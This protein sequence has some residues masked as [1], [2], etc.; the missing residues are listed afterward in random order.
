MNRH[1][2]KD[3]PTGLT[4]DKSSPSRAIK[5]GQVWPLTLAKVRLFG[6]TGRGRHWGASCPTHLESSL[7]ICPP[8]ALNVFAPRASSRGNGSSPP[9]RHSS[10]PVEFCRHRSTRPLIG[11]PGVLAGS[12]F[13]Q[14]W[15]GQPM[16]TFPQ[17]TSH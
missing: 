2:T 1:S 11:R 6:L 5:E 15:R 13:L 3:R 8:R 4:Q 17:D 16:P 7:A 10:I 14:G 9:T 12:G